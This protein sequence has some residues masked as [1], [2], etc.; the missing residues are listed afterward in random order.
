MECRYFG[1]CGSCRL[2]EGGY[3][4]QLQKKIEAIKK[5]FLK[6]YNDEI[7]I[8]TSPQSHYRARAEFR[9]WHE[10]EDI[11]YAMT[12]MEKKALCI[13]ECPQVIQSIAELM[14]KLLD[15]IR[16]LNIS[17][18]LFGCDFL[19]GK[20]AEVVV[21]LL[22]HKKLDEAWLEAAQKIAKKFGIG[23]VGRSRKQKLVVEKDYIIEKLQIDGREFIYKHIE[24]SFTQPNPF[25]NE[26]MISWT[27]QGLQKSERDLLELYCGAGNFTIPFAT[28]FR[29]VLAT[30]ISKTSIKAAQENMRLNDVENIEFVRM[31]AEE[32]TQVLDG[33]RKFNRMKH[34]DIESYEISSVFVD[35]PRAGMDEESCSFVSRFD[36][37]IYI[38]CNPET[39]YRDLERLSATHDVIDL[40]VFDQFSYTHH[41][42]MG[43]KL[44]RKH[45]GAV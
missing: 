40:A 34:I 20:S 36:S 33:V 31:S 26:K 18:K 13:E 30:E 44:K 28:K 38:S 22:Y 32:F 17:H 23:V 7:T 16:F 42:E 1:A 21:S 43:A 3:E 37:I 25:V 9:I 15:E 10:G 6:F 12:S 45:T 8:Y 11:S 5:R 35:P 24:N 14:P 19:S 27:L 2:F 4:A 29:R 39:L 41:I